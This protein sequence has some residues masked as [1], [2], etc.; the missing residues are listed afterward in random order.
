APGT[1]LLVSVLLRPAL[2]AGEVPL[3]NIAA[4]VAAVDAVHAAAG[5]RPGL[6]WPN[7]LVVPG[8]TDQR[9]LAGML[10]E[11]SPSEDGGPP[12]V[13][14]GI[15][16]N[17]TAGAYPEEL[18]GQAISCEE[19]A[20]RPVDRAE[21]LMAFLEAL[22]RRYALLLAGGAAATLDAYRADSATLGR[23]VRV[24]LS[25]GVVE[26]VAGRLTG[27]GELIVVRDDG[28]EVRVSAGDVIH[29]RPT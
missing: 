9:K 13:V 17:V 21:L 18:A 2:P 20:G 16:F 26:G 4:G 24:E 12:A 11:S 27:S 14:V 7:D 3:V 5:F 23:R 6:K 10:S 22:E 15:G 1:S 28:D 29:L 8:S 25:G 19:E